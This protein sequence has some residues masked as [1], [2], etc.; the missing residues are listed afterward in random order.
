MLIF[1]ILLTIIYSPY[2]SMMR[3]LG[4]QKNITMYLHCTLNN[5]DYCGAVVLA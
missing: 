2:K 4:Q 5:P 1:F 3:I